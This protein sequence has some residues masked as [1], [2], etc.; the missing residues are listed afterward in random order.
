MVW[1]KP[2]NLL[3]TGQ[4]YGKSTPTMNLVM[5]WLTM[6]WNHGLLIE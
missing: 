3:S 1:N 5:G 2:E 4:I 6:P